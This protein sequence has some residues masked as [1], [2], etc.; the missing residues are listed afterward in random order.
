MCVCG[1]G[2]GGGHFH[3]LSLFLMKFVVSFDW[4]NGLVI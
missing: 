2:G 1:G 3:L 4:R